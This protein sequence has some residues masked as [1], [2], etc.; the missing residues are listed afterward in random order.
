MW[1]SQLQLLLFAV[2][3]LVLN[4]DWYD[5]SWLLSNNPQKHMVN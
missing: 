1:M 4:W 3:L 5:L 2:M